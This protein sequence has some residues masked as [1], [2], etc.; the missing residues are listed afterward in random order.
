LGFLWCTR[1]TAE[2]AVK[3]PGESFLFTIIYLQ[4][5]LRREAHQPLN[6]FSVLFIHTQGSPSRSIA[7]PACTVSQS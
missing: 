3:L 1:G 5:R 6:L 7:G 2:G 4:M